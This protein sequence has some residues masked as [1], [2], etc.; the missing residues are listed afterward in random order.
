MGTAV[1]PRSRRF[2]LGLAASEDRAL[3]Y[4]AVAIGLIVVLGAII[5]PLT[6][7]R[8]P[9]P[10]ASDAQRLADRYLAAI[11]K[12]KGVTPPADA[13]T[14]VSQYGADGGKTCTESLANL[15]TSAIVHPKPAPGRR[16]ASYVD[17][18]KLEATRT[19]LRV[20]CPTRDAQFATYLKRV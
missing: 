5:V 1:R 9:L 7:S 2:K 18:S 6:I 16:G 4:T 20:Y 11:V 10:A 19:A 12:V 3:V 8:S 13:A 14:V 15:Y 17:H